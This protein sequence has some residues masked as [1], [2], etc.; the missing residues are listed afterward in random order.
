MEIRVLEKIEMTKNQR[1]RLNELGKVQVYDSSTLEQCIER[2]KGADVVVIDWIDPN[3]FLEYMKPKSLLALMSTG[4]SWIDT[5]KAR[6][7]EISVANIPAY[8]TEA[9]AEHLW[10][11][12]LTVLRKIVTGDRVVREGGWEQGQIRGLELKEKTLGVIGLGRIGKR[13][14]EIGEKAF[15]MRAITY[16]RSPKNLPNIREVS[17]SELL[18]ES[19]VISINCGLNPT[20]RDLIGQKEFDL[21][22]ATTVIVSATWG[23]INLPAL[24]VAL[25]NKKILG[26]GLDIAAEG[27]KPELPKELLQLDNVVLTPHVGYNTKESKIRQV[28]ICI[29]NIERFIKGEPQNIVN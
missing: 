2:V 14:T 15:N 10:G 6:S 19:D 29:D 27:G 17:L 5:K 13:M 1:Q 4:Y 16:N 18:K 11:L 23:V 3:G 22:K 20:S 21:V 24:I 28:N 7:L 26:A 8:A 9:V 25:K 12:I